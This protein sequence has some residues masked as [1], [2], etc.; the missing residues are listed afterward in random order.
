MRPLVDP[1]IG[2]SVPWTMCSLDDAS[3]YNSSPTEGGADV[4]LGQV[5]S[6]EGMSMV[7]VSGYVS[8]AGVPC[9]LRLLRLFTA[10]IRTRM[11]GG[12]IGQGRPI[13]GTNRP[14]TVLRGQIGR[15]HIVIA[16]KILP[17]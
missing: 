9:E 17:I 5:R 1:P 6:V 12:G 15:G 14:R 8:D 4:L 10:S 3:P 13:Q 11:G 2:R 7:H 16:S